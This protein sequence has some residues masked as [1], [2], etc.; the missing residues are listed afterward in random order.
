MNDCAIR[1]FFQESESSKYQEKPF[2]YPYLYLV[3]SLDIRTCR[4]FNRQTGVKRNFW[5]AK[6][7]TSHHVR[8]PRVI[9][10]IP[11]AVIKLN[12]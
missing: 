6:F 7:L 10:Y 11:N 8:K 1:N 9:F 4:I 12:I 5:L 3:P 2:G